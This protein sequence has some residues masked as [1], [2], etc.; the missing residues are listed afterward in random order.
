[1]AAQ[2]GPVTTLIEGVA[3]VVGAS[4]VLGGFIVGL[5]A[6]VRGRA[7]ATIEASALD[8]AYIGG[9]GGVLAIVADI[10]IRYAFD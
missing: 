1:M 7:R 9:L 8:A 4:M 10:M 2:I 6:V 5:H 3:T